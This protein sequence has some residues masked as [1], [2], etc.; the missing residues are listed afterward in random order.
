MSN[1]E[2]FWTVRTSEGYIRW[3]DEYESP[4][5]TPTRPDL[6]VSQRYAD[7]VARKTG[8]IVEPYAGTRNL[9]GKRR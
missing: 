8:G 5:F 4:Q 2:G 3:W 7:G 9:K 6:F 1:E